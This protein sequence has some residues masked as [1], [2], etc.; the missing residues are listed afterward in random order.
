MDMFV[1]CLGFLPNSFYFHLVRHDQTHMCLQS[2]SK[3]FQ[4]VHLKKKNLYLLIIDCLTDAQLWLINAMG[5][6]SFITGDQRILH[7][8][9]KEE[10]CQEYLAQ[11]CRQRT[12]QEM[13]NPLTVENMGYFHYKHDSRKTLMHYPCMN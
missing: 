3:C 9:S 8:S 10:W 7:A 2:N 5:L 1:R 4:Q 6:T 12:V 11:Q 13:H